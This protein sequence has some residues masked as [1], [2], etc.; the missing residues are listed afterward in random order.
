[1]CHL[2][3]TSE[4]PPPGGTLMSFCANRQLSYGTVISGIIRD[5]IATPDGAC[6][7][8]TQVLTPAIEADT[9]VF[10]LYPTLP[11]GNYGAADYVEV[12]RYPSGGK[13]GTTPNRK[14]GLLAID[15][16]NYIGAGSIP[17]RAILNL[18]V[19]SIAVS[20]SV[21]SPT[22]M[23]RRT[24]SFDEN[25]ATW[26]DTLA[27][28]PAPEEVVWHATSLGWVSINVTTLVDRCWNNESGVCYWIMS[29]EDEVDNA[30]N[31]LV[32]FGSSE[33][34]DPPTL[35]IEYAP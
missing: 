15:L 33:S 6:L 28:V 17:V 29:E 34:A 24:E 16:N 21:G 5:Y 14:R 10:S 13:G 25:V 27:P 31:S 20:P 26:S 30:T 19:Q 22:V 12:G 23:I 2:Q 18:H 4:L 7:R 11:Q 1:M 35:E 8:Q 9:F 32:S 3:Q